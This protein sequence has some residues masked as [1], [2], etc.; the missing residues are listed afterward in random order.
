[1]TELRQK[2]I[3]NSNS[4][5]KKLV[6]AVC[7]VISLAVIVFI[8]LVSKNSIYCAVA[9]NKA[10]NNDFASALGIIR[11]TT[12]EKSEVL[13]KYI[14]LRI[15]INNF[16][17]ELLSE[18]NGEKI[19]EWCEKSAYINQNADL[20]GEGISAKAQRLSAV[21][22]TVSSLVS[23]YEMQRADVLEMMDIFLEINRLH[24]NGDDGKN[25]G[26]T[27][28]EERAKIER[29]QSLCRNFETYARKIPGYE[30]IYLLSYLIKEVQGECIDL[31]TAVNSVIESGY[32]ETDLVR[33]SGEGRKTYPDIRSSTDSVNLLE[34]NNYE[35]HVHK[36]ICRSLTEALGE[37]YIP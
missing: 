31:G 3:D 10:E 2:N 20:L 1:M 9:E 30:N 25:I 13:E 5:R 12:D 28:Q 35:F 23:E 16:Y 17:P 21:L 34:K 37:F 8:F 22:N 11:K 29:W 18:Y 33:F 27:V 36:S 19:A 4:S 6:A 26:F 32:A 24:T 15:D 7:A 14:E